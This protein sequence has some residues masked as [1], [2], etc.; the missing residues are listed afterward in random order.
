MRVVAVTL[1][2]VSWDS[3]SRPPWRFDWSCGFAALCCTQEFSHFSYH[4]SGG[5][6]SSRRRSWL[7]IHVVADSSHHQDLT[8]SEQNV[9]FN[10]LFES[11]SSWIE[12]A[13]PKLHYRMLIYQL[14]HRESRRCELD[15]TLVLWDSNPGFDPGQLSCSQ[16]VSR[17]SESD[18]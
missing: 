2:R 10:F 3:N 18:F 9:K 7:A 16:I 6:G 17:I 13:T 12:P 5:F 8:G 11:S 4:F 15:P 1:P 14:R